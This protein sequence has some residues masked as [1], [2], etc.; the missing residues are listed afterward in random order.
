MSIA[1][2]QLR[3]QEALAALHALRHT[4]RLD[5]IQTLP[6]YGKTGNGYKG[7]TA[8]PAIGREEDGKNTAYCRNNRRDKGITLLGALSSSPAI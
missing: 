1:H 5:G 7:D 3:R 6:A 2:Q 8:E 4:N